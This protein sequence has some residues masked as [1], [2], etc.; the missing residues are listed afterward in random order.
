MPVNPS[1]YNGIIPQAND[2]LSISQGQILNNFGAIQSLI[3]TD[4]TDFPSGTK[5]A[6][7]HDRVSFTVQTSPPAQNLPNRANWVAGQV[8]MYSALNG[9]TNQN[10][11]YINKTNQATVKQI[12]ATASVLSVTSA[13]GNHITGWTYLPSGIL[14]KWGNSQQFSGLLNIQVN[15]IANQP[16]F[17]GVMS[18]QV[19]T[20][21]TNTS[22]VDRFVR[23]VSTWNI[24][25]NNYFQVYASFRTQVGATTASCEWLAIGY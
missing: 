21:G 16:D 11:L 1:V 13:P 14:L 10:E 15:G 4:H 9:T 8:G 3:Q 17:L 2:F 22:D 20:E 7:Q 25:A 24:P 19:T 6:G 18:I 5:T 12:P 23:L